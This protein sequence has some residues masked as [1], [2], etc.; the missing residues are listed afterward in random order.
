MGVESV[1]NKN[2]VS[3]EEEKFASFLRERNL[4]KTN[5]I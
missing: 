1:G 5:K 4:E 3:N 2:L